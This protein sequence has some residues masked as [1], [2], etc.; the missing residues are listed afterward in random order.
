MAEYVDDAIARKMLSFWRE[1]AGAA[2]SEA[3]A[4][5]APTP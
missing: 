4:T 2:A 5:K 3:A 1:V